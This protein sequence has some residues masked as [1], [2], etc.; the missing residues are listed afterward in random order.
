MLQGRWFLV[1]LVA[2]ALLSTGRSFAQTSDATLTV[3]INVGASSQ[4]LFNNNS[5]LATRVTVFA[6]SGFQ[7]RLSSATN[8]VGPTSGTRGAGSSFD[9]LVDRLYTPAA[10][11]A[12][13]PYTVE[14]TW[15]DTA[16]RMV[17]GGPV[18][19]VRGANTVGPLTIDN[20]APPGSPSIQCYPEPSDPIHALYVYWTAPSPRP[21]DFD[22]YEFHRSTTAGFTPTAATLVTTLPFATTNRTDTSRTP[23]TAHY[24][25]IRIVDQYGATSDR[26]LTTPCRTM[27]LRDAGIDVPM[28]IP[29]DT[30]PDIV[31]VPRDTPQD[32]TLDTGGMPGFTS[33]PPTEAPANRPYVYP[34]RVTHSTG[35]TPTMFSA[36][37]LPS[38]ARIDPMTGAITYNPGFDDVGTQSMVTI[39]ATFSDGSR[40]TQSYTLSVTCPDHDRDGHTDSRCPRMA[41]DDCDDGRAD[42][43]TGA[44]ER[45]NGVDDNCDGVVDEGASDALCG[46]GQACDP[47]TRTC[48]PRCATGADCR[49]DPRVC[50]P[51]G[52]CTLCTPGNATACAGSADGTACVAD[53]AGGVF[54]GCNN[55]ADCGD[56]R[57]G[58]VC[59]TG[60]HVCAPGCSTTPGRNGCPTG[61]RCTASD[62]CTI[63]CTSA[64]QCRAAVPDRPLCPGVS[65]AQC[66]ECASDVDCNGRADGR[67]VCDT[68]KGRC[69]EC[70][71][72]RTLTC[73]AVGRGARCLPENA[74][75]CGA[76]TDC[77]GASSGRICDDVTLQCRAGCRVGGSG[78]CPTGA[79]CVPTPGAM[80]MAGQCVFPVI[81]AGTPDAGPPGDAPP[82][83][84]V[85]E[86]DA[87]ATDSAA[88]SDVA[89]K[90]AAPQDATTDTGA[91]DVVDAGPDSS[92]DVKLY[93]DGCGC[94]S[95]TGARA[96]HGA[97]GLGAFAALVALARRRRQKNP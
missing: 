62:V 3:R 47:L 63:D 27:P 13:N 39:T 14:L 78:G 24:Y 10:A 33:P 18:T 21:L 57:S 40:A 94:R 75:G 25:C 9:V 80:R 32:L 43:F 23:D 5:L 96:S 81:D 37:G 87:T 92:F 53:A 97:Y 74:C 41:G 44:V 36:T 95:A 51:A 31:D 55:D 84:D 90:D 77:G 22:R 85:A 86:N 50:T 67:V 79:M 60:R 49:A 73:V 16:A 12:A 93:S 59:E 65:G 71:P 88:L 58:R 19:L 91:V 38:G 76:D 15:N 35:A 68:A 70:L 89:S 28:D 66:V 46:A 42:T 8:I 7:S 72:G 64:A 82:A 54:C 61:Q 45:C 29:R 26:C 4:G 69:V 52:I 20:Q 48:R 17:T 56:L 34:P 6:R 30:G 2:A 11:G 1:A 83:M